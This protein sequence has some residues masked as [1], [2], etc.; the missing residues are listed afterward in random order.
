MRVCTLRAVEPEL[1]HFAPC[2]QADL[3]RLLRQR[4][5][6]LANPAE[7]T[8]DDFALELCARKVAANSGDIRKALD[9]CRYASLPR[10]SARTHTIPPFA[11]R[12][13]SP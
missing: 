6:M 12:H 13:C 7:L 4:L 3:A 2:S 1:L 11:K 5:A 10:A 8:F 9:V